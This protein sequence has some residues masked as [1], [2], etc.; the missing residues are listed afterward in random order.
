[1]LQNALN[2]LAA[3]PNKV[4]EDDTIVENPWKKVV[5]RIMNPKAILNEQ[6]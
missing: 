2:R 3:L 4:E 6:I 5:T 1:V